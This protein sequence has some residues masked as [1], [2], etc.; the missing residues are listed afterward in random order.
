LSIPVSS[1]EWND[2]LYE[3]AVYE[4][5]GLKKLPRFWK[6]LSAPY[7][8]QADMNTTSF[9]VNATQSLW[10]NAYYPVAQCFHKFLCAYVKGKLSIDN[11]TCYTQSLPAPEMLQQQMIFVDRMSEDASEEFVI[12][13]IINVGMLNYIVNETLFNMLPYE[14]EW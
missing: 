8:Y 9:I 2:W 3:Q 10:S 14:R 1:S 11:S 6:F 7:N 13:N 12:K 4:H 5:N